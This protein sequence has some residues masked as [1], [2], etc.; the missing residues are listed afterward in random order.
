MEGL[1]TRLNAL[2]TWVGV[3]AVVLG[4]VYLLMY[5]SARQR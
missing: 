4:V 5:V 2:T 1:L 3:F